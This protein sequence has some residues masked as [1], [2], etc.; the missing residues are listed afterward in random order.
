MTTTIND[1]LTQAMHPAVFS[2]NCLAAIRAHVTAEQARLGQRPKVIDPFAGTGAIHT[3][4]DVDNVAWTV[5]VELEPEWSCAH[6]RTV[7]GDARN[8]IPQFGVGGFDIVATSPCYGNR[9]ADIYDGRGACRA[10]AGTGF[11]PKSVGCVRCNGTGQDMSRRSTYRIALGR[12][13]TE[14]SSAAMQ[15]GDAYR[16][17]HEVVIGQMLAVLKPGGLA[18]VNMSNH[19]RQGQVQPVVDWWVVTMIEAGFLLDVVERIPTRRYRFGAN[20]GARVD[21]ERLLV[22]RKP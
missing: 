19:I 21:G 1:I 14:G 2:P 3:L 4:E 16:G 12:L 11:Q 15:W 10:C 17:L 20:H 8:L 22:M 7:C 6:E 5:G 13:P 9:M 18:L